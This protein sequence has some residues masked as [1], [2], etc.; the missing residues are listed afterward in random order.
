MRGP[1]SAED[2][3]ASPELN[4]DADAVFGYRCSLEKVT[5]GLIPLRI[6][7]GV[8]ALTRHTTIF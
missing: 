8:E 2:D 1:G 4:S 6:H 5:V 7:G 3:N